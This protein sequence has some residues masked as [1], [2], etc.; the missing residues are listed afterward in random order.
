MSE[1]ID[2]VC[3]AFEAAIREAHAATGKRSII[4]LIALAHAYLAWRESCRRDEK[5]GEVDPERAKMVAQVDA[6]FGGLQVGYVE[7]AEQ[8]RGEIAFDSECDEITAITR[9]LNTAH[10]K[11]AA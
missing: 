10:A 4:T 9:V 11:G 6:L 8:A 5:T 7:V 1:A 3:V 2:P